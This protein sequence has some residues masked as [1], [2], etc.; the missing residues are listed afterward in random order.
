MYLC[1]KPTCLIDSDRYLIMLLR[2]LSL[3][4]PLIHELLCLHG[5]II[6][7]QWACLFSLVCSMLFLLRFIWDMLAVLRF[8]ERAKDR[9]AVQSGRWWSGGKKMAESQ[10]YPRTFGAAASCYVT[11]MCMDSRA[12][13]TCVFC[14]LCSFWVCHV[15]LGGRA[16]EDAARL[17]S[18]FAHP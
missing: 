3:Q 11:N 9:L 13:Q 5:R 4:P 8:G 1:R 6:K 14:Q 15:T 10:V 16:F 17:V 2:F 7:L 12:C 18:A